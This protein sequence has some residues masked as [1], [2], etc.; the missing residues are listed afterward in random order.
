MKTAIVGIGGV[1]GYFGG[2]LA[3]QYTDDKDVEIVFIARGNHLE[4]I[5][6]NGLKLI[7]EKETM[8]VRPDLATDDP[9]GCGV[10]DC[11]IFCVKAYDLENSAK[12]LSPSI[13]ENTQVITLL[14]GVDNADK[15]RVLL[16]KGKILNGCVYISGLIVQPGVVQQKG[17]LT[18][19]FFGNES[20]EDIDGK[21]LET[22]FK[23][24]NID[25]QYRTDIEHI[26][27]EKY[28][29]IS[30][31]ASATTYLQKTMHGVLDNDD[32]KELLEKLLAEVLSIAKAKQIVLPEN[33]RDQIVEKVS[34]FPKTTKTSMQT[35]FEKGSRA[36]LETFTGYIVREARKFGIPVPTHEYVYDVLKKGLYG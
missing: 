23:N 32:G 3:K 30:P 17:A 10:F 16:N 7:T 29:F 18:R 14:N 8:V 1:G 25:A 5:K 4:Q 36:E 21:Q 24:A 33:I 26:A 19:L 9:S 6:K 28:V 11:V 20:D 12:R 34:G 13:G 15:L 2:L 31:F 27:W 35:D 22:F